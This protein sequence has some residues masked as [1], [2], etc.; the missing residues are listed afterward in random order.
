MYG[1]LHNKPTNIRSFAS[2]WYRLRLSGNFNHD[3]AGIKKIKKENETHEGDLFHMI[4]IHNLTILMSL[5]IVSSFFDNGTLN[6]LNSVLIF[7]L[8]FCL[9]INLFLT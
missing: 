3:E 6:T 2:F 1:S 4:N 9:N 8:L 7:L 5:S